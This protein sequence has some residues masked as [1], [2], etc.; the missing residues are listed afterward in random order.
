MKF[1]QDKKRYNLSSFFYDFSALL[2]SIDMLMLYNKALMFPFTGVKVA[3]VAR[4]NFIASNALS[5]DTDSLNYFTAKLSNINSLSVPN[6]RLLFM[7]G[8]SSLLDSLLLINARSSATTQSYLPALFPLNRAKF[9][10]HALTK[11]SR[12]RLSAKVARNYFSI[13]GS[14]SLALVKPTNNLRNLSNLRK[15]KILSLAIVNGAPRKRTRDILHF[16][17]VTA[18]L[19]SITNTPIKHNFLKRGSAKNLVSQFSLAHGTYSTLTSINYFLSSHLMSYYCMYNPLFIKLWSSNTASF[20][21]NSCVTTSPPDN[22]FVS[23][24]LNFLIYKKL[25]QFIS[26]SFMQKNVSVCYYN[27]FIRFLSYCTGL[28]VLLQYYSSI[29]ACVDVGSVTLYKR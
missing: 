26:N 5:L 14:T 28:N 21:L 18:P 15:K 23:T 20:F 19:H 8:L 24:P 3:F 11:K 17:A 6:F 2:C 9:T 1:G 16:L 25:R 29:D 22:V 4:P 27:T 13:K 10:Q 12:S 7:S